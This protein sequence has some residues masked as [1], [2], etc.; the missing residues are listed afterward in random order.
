MDELTFVFHIS[1][2]S[3]TFFQIAHLIPIRFSCL[4]FRARSQ[5]SVVV[6][7][8]TIVANRLRSIRLIVFLGSHNTSIAVA[9]YL[10]LF[11]A[12][13][14][15]YCATKGLDGTTAPIQVKR[16]LSCHQS[17]QPGYSPLRKGSFSCSQQ[18]QSLI[19]TTNSQP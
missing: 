3:T 18:I 7:S 4:R 9:E 1:K 13:R 16:R 8:V 2:A 15:H 10:N 6:I 12:R 5:Y 11:E 14:S 19:Q 17:S